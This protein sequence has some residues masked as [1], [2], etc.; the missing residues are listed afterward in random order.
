[1][2]GINLIPQEIKPKANVLKT[3][4]L[5]KKIAITE[6]IFL[7][8]FAI[9]VFGSIFIL[10]SRL[11]DSH[12]KDDKLRSEIK[13]LEQTEQ[14]LMLVKDRLGKIENIYSWDD[15]SQEVLI[16]EGVVNT[17]PEGVVLRSAVLKETQVNLT[18]EVVNS[19][20]FSNLLSS[21]VNSGKYKTIKIESLDFD[22]EK[23]YIIE[24]AISI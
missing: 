20:S 23:G 3:A 9:I 1:M 5:L 11:K 13:A 21:L 22:P 4:N 7:L 10:S 6:S 16:A 15:A 19:E 8:V 12:S 24:L 18:I 2:D 17:L 14:R